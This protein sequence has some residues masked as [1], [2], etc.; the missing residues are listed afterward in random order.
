MQTQDTVP[1]VATGH[2]SLRGQ[3]QQ[4]SLTQPVYRKAALYLL[5]DPLVAL[6]AHICQHVFN[7]VIRPGG[8]LQGTADWIM[9]LADGAIVEMVSKQELLH[10]TGGPHESSGSRQTA[11]R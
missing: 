8:L 9:V 6:D 2:E 3:K 1:F 4:M 11:R 7:Q 5:D 10:K